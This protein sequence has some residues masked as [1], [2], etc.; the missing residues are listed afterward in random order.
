MF[1]L[2]YFTQQH[3]TVNMLILKLHTKHYNITHYRSCFQQ[4]HRVIVM[5]LLESHC[6]VVFPFFCICSH[7]ICDEHASRILV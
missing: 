2:T 5:L 4:L 3:I 1:S 7:R 6:N